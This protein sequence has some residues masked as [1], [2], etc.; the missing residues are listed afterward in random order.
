MRVLTVLCR[1][2]TLAIALLGLYAVR[3]V[4]TRILSPT[5]GEDMATS[6]WLTVGREYDVLEILA[7]P[8]R[9]VL[10]RI[11]TDESGAPGL[12]DSRLFKSVDMRVPTSWSAGLQADG[13]LILAP[14]IGTG[15]ASG[16]PISTGTRTRSATTT[17]RLRT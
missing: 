3:V 8:G 6:P 2:L 15:A 5:T 4:C 13:S 14:R 9:E 7:E 10:F 1:A 12:W 17:M 16:R 11:A